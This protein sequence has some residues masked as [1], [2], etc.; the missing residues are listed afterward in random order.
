[1]KKVITILDKFFDVALTIGMVTAF[2][3]CG[4][5][6]YNFLM[7]GELQSLKAAGFE[8]LLAMFAIWAKVSSPTSAQADGARSAPRETGAQNSEKSQAKE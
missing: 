6:L 4:V 8:L 1:M 5:A 3:F 2:M 7:T